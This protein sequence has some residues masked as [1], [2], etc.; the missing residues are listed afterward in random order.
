M[1]FSLRENSVWVSRVRDGSPRTVARKM[2]GKNSLVLNVVADLNSMIKL[3]P[4]PSLRN[5]EC[6]SSETETPVYTDFSSFLL[7]FK[8]LSLK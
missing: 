1:F 5:S 2:H 6:E 8:H 7:F 4:N 3:M